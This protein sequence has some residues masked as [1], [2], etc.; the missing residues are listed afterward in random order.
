MS[1]GVNF[2]V[3][4]GGSGCRARLMAADGAVL[5][6][7]VAGPC[8]PS[9]DL[10]RA[11]ASFSDAWRECSAKAGRNAGQVDDVT[12]AIGGAGLYVAPVR[13][14]F[15]AAIPAFART[16][17]MSDG[18]SALIG[19]G[20]GRPAGLIIAG[21]GVVAHRLYA[22]G[23]SFQRDGWGWIGGDRGSGA[24]IGRRALRHA[25]SVLDGIGAPDALSAAVIAMLR[26]DDRRS[27]GWMVGLGPERLASLVPLVLAAGDATSAGILRQAARHLAD[28]AGTLDL[29]AADTLYMAGGLAAVLRAPIAQLL[30]REVATPAA[31]AMA[32]CFL[33]ASGAAPPESVIEHR[34]LA[35][36]A[37]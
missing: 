7:A 34:A 30:G 14:A 4:A 8:N 33:V 13:A 19:A 3:D 18:Y 15:L 26:A 37:P 36:Q 2:C 24:W 31:D 10:A 17:A 12:L 21:T 32:G 25:L 22:D 28:L 5:A 9:T 29:G 16:L 11:T 35:E 27:G 20:G 1:A 6:E 23:R